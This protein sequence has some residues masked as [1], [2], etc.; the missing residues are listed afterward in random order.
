MKLRKNKIPQN[1]KTNLMF[2][3][4]LPMKD[5]IPAARQ[6]VVP[7]LTEAW[8]KVWEEDERRRKEEG[9]NQDKR[10]QFKDC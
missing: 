10:N 2:S 7:A 5:M 9:K 8:R 4:E 1:N 3:R 6:H